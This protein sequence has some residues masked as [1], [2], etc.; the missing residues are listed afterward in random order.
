M[1]K[2]SYFYTRSVLFPFFYFL[3]KRHTLLFLFQRYR[4]KV[5]LRIK[6]KTYLLTFLYRV[7]LRGSIRFYDSKMIFSSLYGSVTRI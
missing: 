5:L 1:E 4:G 3:V 7:T 2:Q 6:L